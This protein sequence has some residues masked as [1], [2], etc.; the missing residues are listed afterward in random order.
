MCWTRVDLCLQITYLTWLL[1][2]VRDLIYP[3]RMHET[4]LSSL[5]VVPWIGEFYSC[6]LVM[7][8][9]SDR[10]VDMVYFD[11]GSWKVTVEFE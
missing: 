7:C 5:D 3:C 10:M 11:R 1:V 8:G 4:C 6:V 9:G 2:V